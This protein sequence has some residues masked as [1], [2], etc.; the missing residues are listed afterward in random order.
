MLMIGSKRRAID[1]LSD[2]FPGPSAKRRRE[3]VSLCG[4]NVV[5]SHDPHLASSIQGRPKHHPEYWFDDGNVVVVAG[6]ISY[7]V[8]AGILS[9]PSIV[10]RQLCAELRADSSQ[11]IAGC[12]IL[13]LDDSPEDMT[14]L[15]S[16]LYGGHR[17]VDLSIIFVS[18]IA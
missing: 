2:V 13:T 9:R 15:I 16:N 10:L 11:D 12:P 17:C 7:R 4:G 18:L 6:N 1:D 5:E 3:T 8:H 14:A